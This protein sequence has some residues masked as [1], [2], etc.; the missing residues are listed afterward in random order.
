MRFRVSS[1]KVTGTA[2]SGDSHNDLLITSV[3]CILVAGIVW[4][5]F[6]QTV[7]HDFVN[8]DDDSYVYANPRT[9]NGLTPGNV[10]WAFTHVHQAGLWHPLT[11]ISHM[12]DCQIYGLWAGGHH[13]TNILLHAAASILLFLALCELTGGR[14]AIAGMDHGGRDHRSGLLP[15]DSL[16]PSA[17]VAALFAIHPMQVESVAW[18]AERKNVLSAVFFMLTLLAYARYARSDRFLL[19]RY[20]TV[21]VCFAL[22][23]MCKP[24]LVTLPFV[25]LLLDYWPLCRI[26]EPKAVAPP[27]R[28]QL[29]R[30]TVAW[31]NRSSWERLV[32]EKIPFFM[33]SALC[34]VATIFA[35]RTLIEAGPLQETLANAMVAYVQY[36]GRAIYPA[37]LAFRYLYPEGGP[38]IAEVIFALLFLLVVSVIFFLWRKPYP[39][40]LT[41]WLWF[42]GMLVPTIGIVQ[43]YSQPTCDHYTYL[44]G[45]GLY[46]VATWG[47]IRLFD[48]WSSKREVLA[49]A[50]VLIIGGLIA[51]SYFQ[52]SYWLNSETL[53][54]HT[55][56][57][58]SRNYIAL[59]SLAGTLLEKDQLD[60]A[61]AYY[62]RAVEIKPDFCNKECVLLA[63]VQSNLGNALLRE[64]HV[65]EAILHLQN[66]LHINPVYA[67]AYNHMG[68]AL[69]KKG[70]VDKAIRYYQEAVQ[71]DTSYAD[72]HNNLG[73]AFLRNGQLDEAVAHLREALRLKPG[74]EE[75]KKHLRELGVTAAQ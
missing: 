9:I 21:L 49:V 66:A 61:I 42:L 52:T 50:A 24:T 68:S 29:K 34:C 1:K 43:V 15:G 44:P 17:F 75:A 16:W 69:M 55:I 48:K 59:D 54:R 36:L 20:I 3:V 25:L 64:G 19:S 41:G 71:L 38:S 27:L 53:W 4:I 47:A 62:K 8:C 14:H 13:L 45:I 23:L 67:E 51:R 60:E 65:D 74:Y 35:T 7:R 5:A 2:A 39:F 72:A 70:Q 58:T 56:D 40:A 57:V 28:V 73:M 46:I 12:L 30:R 11:T 26:Q 18:V 10:Q 6:G 33:L 22:G 37:H 32:I 63:Q 31:L